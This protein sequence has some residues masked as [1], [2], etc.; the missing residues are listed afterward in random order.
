MR[1]DDHH[2][3]SKVLCQVMRDLDPIPAFKALPGV[4]AVQVT[5]FTAGVGIY[6]Q[7]ATWKGRCRPWRGDYTPLAGSSP[8]IK[9]RM[10][11]LRNYAGCL[12]EYRPLPPLACEV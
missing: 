2:M 1:Q 10:M 7:G 6:A 9:V 3:Q 8:S 11:N 5:G 4:A 12:V